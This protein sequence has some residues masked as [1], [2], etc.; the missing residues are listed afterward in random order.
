MANITIDLSQNWFRI[1]INSFLSILFITR[2]LFSGTIAGIILHFFVYVAH[3]TS[4]PPICYQ[5]IC[6]RFGSSLIYMYTK[7]TPDSPFLYFMTIIHSSD[8]FLLLFQSLYTYIERLEENKLERDDPFFLELSK[9]CIVHLKF[10]SIRIGSVAEWLG[11]QA[12]DL[13]VPG[14]IPL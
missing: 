12:Q 4:L 8:F 7:L 9:V 3:L 2:D 11:R 6:Y 13:K 5:T 1:S 10:E 14:S